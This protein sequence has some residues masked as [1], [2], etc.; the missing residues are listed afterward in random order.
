M[1]RRSRSATGAWRGS[2]VDT[3]RHRAPEPDSGCGLYAVHPHAVEAALAYLGGRPGGAI[4]GIVE[5]WGRV[6]L[7]EG[8]FR[9]QYARPIAFAV[10]A[11]PASGD[12][13]RTAARIA[14][15]YRAELVPVLDP[16]D[17]VLYCQGRGWGLS[18][19]VV[20]SL[21]PEEA[22]AVVEPP[23]SRTGVSE[24]ARQR[25]NRRRRERAARR[26]QAR[27]GGARPR[28]RR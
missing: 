4:A 23:V 25:R 20:A 3:G 10:A 11:E 7:H 2:G 9:A 27:A 26:R 6:E 21:V 1:S 12:P 17:L 16:H 28:R 13:A 24:L 5:A 18:P 19:E 22:P 15:G 14:H 8:G